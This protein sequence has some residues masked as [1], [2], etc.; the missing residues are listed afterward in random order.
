MSAIVSN[1]EDFSPK[2]YSI[3]SQRYAEV[4]HNYLQS[5][6]IQKS[7]PALTGDEA[8]QSRLKELIPP[9]AKGLDAGCGAGARDVYKMVQLG[10]DMVGIDAISENIDTALQ[11]HP[12][13]ENRV[14]VHNLCEQLPFE[15]NS[16]DFV[17]CNAVIQHIEPEFVYKSVLPELTRIVKSGGIFQFM[18]K[19]GDGVQTL[20]D[21]DY[22]ASRTFQLYNEQTILD[23]LKELGMELI[24]PQDEKLGGIMT[25]VDPKNSSHAVMFLTK[26]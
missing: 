13:L 26:Q 1:Q 5:V 25:F 16:F 10:Y 23:S 20:F 12:E 14:F 21:K 24:Q 15:S 3:Y 9:N 18:F 7:H 4:A 8:L 19:N 6:Y 11:W 2:F 17:T 22:N